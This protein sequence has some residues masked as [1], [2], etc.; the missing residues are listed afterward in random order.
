MPNSPIP[1]PKPRRVV[2][3]HNNE[4]L[5]TVRH[6]SYLN[7]QPYGDGTNLTPFWYTTEQPADVSRSQDKSLLTPSGLP[8]GSGFTA[9]DLPPQSEGLFH[10]SI[11]LDY[12]IVVKGSV[13]LG[14]DDGSRVTLN[15][16]D[17]VVQQ[18]TMHS[19]N[20]VSTEWARVYGI[21]VPAQA[22]TINGKELETVWPL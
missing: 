6:D 22:P 10:R 21:M 3:G 4:G 13:V 5:A 14:L 8:T 1:L 11:T 18:A 16:G 2:T 17:V 7:I 15:E 12:V 19:W 20:N 9:Y